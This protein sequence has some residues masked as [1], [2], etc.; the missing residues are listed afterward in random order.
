[1]WRPV[2]TLLYLLH[3]SVDALTHLRSAMSNQNR[4]VFIDV[5]QS[6]SLLLTQTNTITV[7]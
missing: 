7:N 1:M 2:D 4:A 3:F 6:R 5:D